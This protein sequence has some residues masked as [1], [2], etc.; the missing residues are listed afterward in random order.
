MAMAMAAPTPAVVIDGG[1]VPP[2]VRTS[3]PGPSDP[4]SDRADRS[5]DFD[6]QATFRDLLSNRE[7]RALLGSSGLSWL[8]DYLAKAAVATLVY[9]QTGSVVATAATFAISY[10]PWLLLGPLLSAMAE[11]HPYR[12]VMIISDL[13]RMVLMALVALPG[14]PI[15]ALIGLLFLTSLGNPPYESA[16]SAL[17]P[18]ILPGDRLALGISLSISLGQACQMG[19]YLVGGLLASINPRA[20][21]LVDAATFGLSALLLLGF[22]KPRPAATIDVPRLNL[23]RE[24][25]DGFRVVFGSP[26]LRSISVIVFTTMLFGI[27][28]EGL[29]AVWA[30]DLVPDDSGDRGF[31]QGLIMMAHPAGVVIGGLAI[32]RLVPPVLR[33]KLIRPFALLAP[34]TLTPALLD[35]PLAGV[36]VMAAACGFLQA[37]MVPTANVLFVQAL[38]PYYRARAFGVMQSGVQL[39]Q[40]GA[41]LAVGALVALVQLQLSTVVGLWSLGGAL[42]VLISIAA[43]PRQEQFT[44]AIAHAR[45]V[46]EP[47]AAPVV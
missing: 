29:A 4:P 14:L 31:A 26:V 38:P 35:P 6:R 28:P 22:V 3:A 27:L 34:L 17:L 44:A 25:G 2:P 19:G 33:R 16:R 23:L 41:V 5:D 45:A 12:T 20:A 39:I 37:G 18:N 24:T 7:Y 8:G 15:P 46:N 47:A 21:L 40:G 43:W 13:A 30:A 42:L 10:A 1:P 11:R 36:C 32:G 9:Q